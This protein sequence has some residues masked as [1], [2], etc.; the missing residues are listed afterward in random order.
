MSIDLQSS[1][2]AVDQ[3]KWSEIQEIFENDSCL[4][5]SKVQLECVSF[6]YISHFTKALQSTEICHDY[7]CKTETEIIK[8]KMIKNFLI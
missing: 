5:E 7:S 4:R 1:S 3:L 2:K 6:P 8:L